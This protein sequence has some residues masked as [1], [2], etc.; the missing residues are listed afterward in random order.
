MVKHRKNSMQTISD[1][2]S[3]VD[4]L[5]GDAAVA[6]WLNTSVGNVVMMKSRGYVARGFHLHFYLT[7]RERGALV[8]PRLFDLETFDHL[9]MPKLRR[10]AAKVNRRAA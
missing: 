2:R 9:I 4:F 1:M 5:G 8:T 10:R 7:L 3:A 6:S